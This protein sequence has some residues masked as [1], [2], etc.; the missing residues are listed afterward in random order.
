MC[1]RLDRSRV[2]RLFLFHCC[3]FKL[4]A[5]L[6]CDRFVLPESQ[7]G[8]FTK[9]A[10]EHSHCAL[11]KTLAVSAR[12]YK[13]LEKNAPPYFTAFSQSAKPY[14]E[15][16]RDLAIIVVNQVRQ[17]YTLTKEYLEEKWPI[18]YSTIDG[19]APGFLKAVQEYSSASWSTV[20]RLSI[21]Y[22][23][24]TLS[25]LQTKVFMWV[26]YLSLCRILYIKF[27]IH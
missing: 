25:Y 21:Q 14:G 12:G 5:R 19:Y 10:L 17:F 8:K 1:H 3:I 7:T 16:L 11:S 9:I 24:V 20:K 6:T 2:K 23:D 4:A 13:Y 18:V 15:L 22:Y 27:Y 26:F